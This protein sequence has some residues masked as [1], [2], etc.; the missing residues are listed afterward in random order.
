[1]PKHRIPPHPNS[2]TGLSEAKKILVSMI[3]EVT[4]S[5]GGKREYLHHI[6]KIYWQIQTQR[7]LQRQSLQIFFSIQERQEGYYIVYKQ[8]SGNF[9]LFLFL[10]LASI[11]P[12]NKQVH[13]LYTCTQALFT[14]FSLL[15]FNDYAVNVGGKKLSC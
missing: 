2:G 8:V 7:R 14:F 1:M 5:H 15:Y 13:L 6:A 3:M 12:K 11:F 4:R 10:K 9:Q